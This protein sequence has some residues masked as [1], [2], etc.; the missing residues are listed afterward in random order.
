MARKLPWGPA[1]GNIC[2]NC[3]EAV[4]VTEDDLDKVEECPDEGTPWDES[5]WI[6]YEKKGDRDQFPFD[7]TVIGPFCSEKCLLDW[8][9]KEVSKHG[10]ENEKKKRTKA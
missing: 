3:D 10:K 5:I 8:M 9:A 6:Q 1:L 7:M 4:L 2:I